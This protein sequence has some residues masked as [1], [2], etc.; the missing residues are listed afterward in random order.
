V[1]LRLIEKDMTVF[2]WLNA[3]RF[4]TTGQL[5]L[6]TGESEANAR[7][8]LSRL[9]KANLLTSSRALCEFRGRRQNCYS[10]ALA[11]AKKLAKVAPAM[12]VRPTKGKSL[13]ASSHLLWIN[14]IWLAVHRA[15]E[16]QSY[17]SYAFLPHYDYDS[18]SPDAPTWI[19]SLARKKG[20]KPS[21][22]I[23]DFAL[24]VKCRDGAS[25]FFGEVDLAS[26]SL[27]SSL[28]SRA[29]FFTKLR[30]YAAFHDSNG[31]ERLADELGESFSGFGVLVA[32][33]SARR[34]AN[35]RRLCA[36]LGSSEFVRVTTL[37]QISH[38]TVF[39]P[40]WTIGVN[41]TP[42]PLLLRHERLGSCGAEEAAPSAER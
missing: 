26:E 28:R 20:A 5:A 39:G 8:R 32:T 33:S 13:P 17:Y 9:G 23:A 25:L 22:V 27:D 34:A 29:T 3:C 11:N 10:V 40:I 30:A 41:D 7:R 2:R 18:S 21:A 15:M 4:L 36:R 1:G 38:D 12:E 35:I 14:Q 19:S 16:H 37:D 6:G 42:R 24:V 31:Y